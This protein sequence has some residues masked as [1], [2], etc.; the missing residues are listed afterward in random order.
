MT[1]TPTAV[2]KIAGEVLGTFV[3]VFFGC[4]AALISGG[5]YVATGAGLRPHRPG[6][7]LRGRPDLRRAL[8]PR[9]DARRGAGRPARRGARSSSTSAPS[10]SARSPP[11]LCL[12]VLMHGFPGYDST[13]DGLA[14]NSFGDGGTGYAWW[15]AFLLEMLMTVRL[16]HGHPR[17]DRQPRTS[18]RCMA[19]LA[20]GLALAMIH[21]ASINATGTSV[22]PARSIGV[23]ALRRHRRDHPALAVHPGPAAR[24]RARRPALPRALRRRRPGPGLGP[25]LPARPGGRRPG[26]GAPDQYQQQWNQPDAQPTV[27]YPQQGAAAAAVRAAAR[28]SSST[29]PQQQ[30]G[31]YQYAEAV[32]TAAAVPAARPAAVPAA[33]VPPRR[34]TRRSRATRSRAAGSRRPRPAADPGDAAAAS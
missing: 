9:R 2:H 23:G 17:R 3:L 11:V 32:P 15:A 5:D 6:D 22:N 27:Q 34:A 18:T 33:A 14:Q 25:A 26:Y 21:F 30:Y 10:S 19:P 1:D 31:G 13:T 24:R 28:H 8:Q 4:G 12:W 20:I 16:H 7:G 29:R